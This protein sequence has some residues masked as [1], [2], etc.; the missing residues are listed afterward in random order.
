MSEDQGESPP[1][2][3][4]DD[5]LLLLQLMTRRAI[6][7]R[8]ERNERDADEESGPALAEP[9]AVA[10]L[11]DRWTLL[12]EGLDLYSWQKECLERWKARGNGTIKVATGGGKTLF[13][14]AAAQ[15]L[16]NE[17]EPDLRLVIVV[18]TIPL[19]FQWRDEIARGNLPASAIGLLGGSQELAPLSG[20]RILVCV[21]NSARDRL[22]ELVR[23]AS[24]SR[25]MLL[26]VDEC[27]RGAADKA[28]RIFE[29]QPRYTLGLSATPEQ[30]LDASD[31]SSDAKYA[32]SDVGKA[33]G[34]II[35]DFTLKQSLEAGL[36]TPFEVWHVGLPLNSPEWAEHAK[37][38][39]EI[40]DLRKALQIRYNSAKSNQGFIPWCQTQASRKGPAAVEAERF[41]G[42]ANRRKRL[43][44]GAEARKLVTL[45][46]LA[47]CLADAETRG[48]VFH[49]S[50]AEIEELFVHALERGIPAVLEHSQL[51][52]GLRSENIEA[53]REG[54]A[55]VIISA[56]SLVEGF[57]VPSA[58]LGII[59]ASSGS[60]R[61]RI[62]SL[63]R[64]LRKKPGG[65]TARILVL[66]VKDTEDEAIYEKADWEEVIGAERNR[67]FDW[68]PSDE[69]PAQA[70]RFEET[71][72][73]PRVYKP[74]S[75]E[76]DVTALAQGAP[77]PAQ[78][79]GRDV[80][81]DHAGNLRAEDGSLWEAPR[82]LV[83]AVI[84]RNSFRRARVTPT[85][86]LIVRIDGPSSNE[87]DW[88]F[89]GE[90][91]PEPRP[92]APVKIRFRLKTSS[93]KTVIAKESE[94]RKGLVPFAFGPDRATNPEAG[95]ARDQLLEW[96]RSEELRLSSKILDLFWDGRTT[97]WIEING[98]RIDHPSPL[99][100]LEF[101]E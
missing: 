23:R 83:E 60:V 14:L 6:W 64:M 48:I 41:I 4:D 91:G 99:A 82:E 11:P 50:I 31:A 37:L 71:Q 77:Y 39:S 93:G 65:R 84:E 3:S 10:P 43:L 69:D 95:Q 46:L 8:R 25:R 29:S 40:T 17:K 61:Q 38:S 53:F 85:G 51:S 94:R 78:A 97:Y 88:R 57:N 20:L 55:K 86:H 87:P 32:E 34:P 66:Y 73:P 68:I 24:W 76:I 100:A 45:Q 47:E 75:S 72:T 70:G 35:Y 36:L 28:K 1:V 92:P 74:P 18:P 59:V 90:V 42:L 89:L 58:D 26:V 52:D 7:E 21:I 49:E 101:K 5:R 54:V 63:G 44:Y 81:V 19:M 9:T 2:F 98:E 12:P 33:L 22:P 79:H 16:Q 27:H 80:K 56:K 13:A 67:Y 15:E 30:E 96:I 62:Q